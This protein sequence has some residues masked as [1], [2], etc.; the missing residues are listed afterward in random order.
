MKTPVSPC[1]KCIIRPICEN[2][3]EDYRSFVKTS[4]LMDK[5]IEV[6]GNDLT[7]KEFLC[8]C[9]ITLRYRKLYAPKLIQKEL[10][11]GVDM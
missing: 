10:N 2:S 6:Y 7:E 11:N 5:I 9:D 4:K 1:F 3:C 8:I